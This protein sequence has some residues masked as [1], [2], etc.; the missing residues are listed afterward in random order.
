MHRTT[1]PLA[2]QIFSRNADVDRVNAEELA[3]LPGAPVQCEAR[4]EVELLAEA[5][6]DSQ[7]TLTNADI[8]R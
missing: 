7:G 4:D 3:R 1:Q 6:P 8:A 2:L 5:N